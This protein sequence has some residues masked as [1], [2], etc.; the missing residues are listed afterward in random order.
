MKRILLLSVLMLIC[1]TTEHEQ[2]Q[3]NIDY[4]SKLKDVIIIKDDNSQICFTNNW[5]EQ[6]RT[7]LRTKAYEIYAQINDSNTFLLNYFI[8]EELADGFLFQHFSEQMEPIA[9]IKC[10]FNFLVKEINVFE[11]P[12]T[13]GLKSWWACTQREYFKSKK[14]M[15]E[16]ENMILEICEDW[17]PIK[18]TNAVLSGLYCMGIS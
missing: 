18:T 10:D 8:I 3:P 11:H 12:E 9:T 6:T 4:M 17:L 1:C 15:E 14:Q 5:T 2:P 13:R 16:D 7:G